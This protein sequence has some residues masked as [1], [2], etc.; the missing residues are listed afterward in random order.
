MNKRNL[1]PLFCVF[2]L[3]CLILGLSLVYIKQQ[4][5]YL[6][7]TLAAIGG[8]VFIVQISLIYRHSSSQDNS[9]RWVSPFSFKRWKKLSMVIC[10][11]TGSM[12]FI[13]VSHYLANNSNL[14]W[15]VTQDKQHTLSNNTKE[16]VSTLAN[17]VQ[18]T[19]FHVGMPPKYLLDLFKEYERVSKGVIKTE[20]IDPIEQIAYAA[21]FGNAI[22]ADERK[23]IVQSGSNR[24]GVD[25]TQSVLSEDKL[26]NAIASVSRAPRTVYFLTGHGEYSSSNVEFTGLSKFKQLLSDNNIT[27][28]TLMLGISQSI[29]VDCDVLIIAGPKTQLSLN[30][31]TVI[32]DYLTIGGDALFLIEHTLVTTP[33]NPLSAEQLQKNPSLNTILNQWGLDVQ[34]DIVVDLTNHIGDD[35]GSPATKNYQRHKALTEGLDYTFYVRPRSIHVLPQ[36]RASIKHAVIVSTAS[37]ENSWAETNRTL[38]IQFDP[39]TD[40]AGPIPFAYVVIEEKNDGLAEDKLSDTRLIVFTDADFL[41]NVY[42]EQYSNAQMGLNLVNWLAELDYKTYISTKETKVER[43][44]LTSQQKRQVIVILFLLPFFLAISGLMVWLRTKMM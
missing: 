33:D 35:V 20:I 30:E 42:I 2:G 29:P 41:S 43:L 22:N 15:D 8:I 1:L 12:A 14:R 19:A 10:I 26:T 13:G 17:E 44:D 37:T 38:D 18:L 5:S 40:T 36:R 31:E 6:A 21:K 34:S 32:S 28:K 16:Y 27:S 25:F 11:V 7:M 39:S 23:V 3:L 4:F 9:S 24:K